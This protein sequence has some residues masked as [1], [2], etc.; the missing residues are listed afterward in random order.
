MCLFLPAISILF[1]KFIEETSQL[2]YR[3]IRRGGILFSSYLLFT[4][5]YRH[6]LNVHSKGWLRIAWVEIIRLAGFDLILI[7]CILHYL[8]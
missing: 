3:G 7:Y 1:I 2:S 4:Q 6:C 8:S 5:F